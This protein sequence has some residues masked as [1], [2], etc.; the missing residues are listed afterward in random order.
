[1]KIYHFDLGNS[2]K[3][4]VGFCA[5]VRAESKEDAV[6]KFRK[7][8]DAFEDGYEVDDGMM[9][10]SVEYCNVYFNSDAITENDIDDEREAD[11]E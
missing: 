7:Y 10:R 2:T 8:I 3:G 11:E 5:D 6:K 1:M 9:G 4:P